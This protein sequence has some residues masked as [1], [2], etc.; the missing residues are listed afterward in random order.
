M[1]RQR[2]LRKGRFDG[3][4]G[5]PWSWPQCTWEGRVPKWR[6]AGTH[7]YG[8]G[9]GQVLGLHS[10]EMGPGHLEATGVPIKPPRAPGSWDGCPP[11]PAHPFALTRAEELQGRHCRPGPCLQRIRSGSEVASRRSKGSYFAPGPPGTG[12]GGGGARPAL[13]LG[14]FCSCS[15]RGARPQH[16]PCLGSDGGGAPG[17]WGQRPE[18]SE[19][20]GASGRKERVQAELPGGASGRAPREGWGRRVGVGGGRGQCRGSWTVFQREGRPLGI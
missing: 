16:P 7:G 8:S 20:N 4:R 11:P 3:G 12:H 6:C 9:W 13:P 10:P 5:S 18:G 1:L 14:N 15:C 19:G 2:T 17:R